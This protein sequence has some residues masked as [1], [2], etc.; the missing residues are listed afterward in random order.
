MQNSSFNGSGGI[1]TDLDGTAIHENRGRTC[2]AKP[3]ESALKE[4]HALGHPFILNSLRFPLSVLRT[5]GREW[6]SISSAPIPLVSLNGSLTGFIRSTS[7]GELVFDEMQCFPLSRSEV[8]ETLTGVFGLLQN[9]IKEL[10]LFYYPRDWRVGEIIW[11]PVAERVH[12]VKQKYVSASAVTSVRI[13][14][15]RDQLMAEEICMIFLLIDAPQ[16]LLMAYQ[17]T[18]RSNF[19]THRNINKLS[20]AQEICRHLCIELGHSV[21]AG[22]TELDTFLPGVGLAIIVG[23]SP[24]EFRGLV[25]TIKVADSRQLGALLF[26]L[27]KLRRG[28]G[29]G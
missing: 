21:G 17:H 16:D 6:Y 12:T 7:E 2:I 19:L 11:T 27:A 15:L 5:F 22:D 20:G 14:K 9:N 18:K 29:H 23:N 26:S 25:D 10:L 13:E 4:L 3:V 24:V 8:D 28:Q 1:V